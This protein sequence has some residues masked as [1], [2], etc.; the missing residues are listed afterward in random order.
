MNRGRV[1][2][3]HTHKIK[4]KIST[5]DLTIWVETDRLV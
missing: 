4:P 3:T 5:R 1:R 2:H